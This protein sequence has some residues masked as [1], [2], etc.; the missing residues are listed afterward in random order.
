[1]RDLVKGRDDAI[2]ATR[3]ARKRLRRSDNLARESLCGQMPIDLI[4]AR[5]GFIHDAKFNAGTTEFTDRFILRCHVAADG[6]M[7]SGLPIPAAIG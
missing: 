5:A 2:K 3:H 6:S 7:G 4:A 1:M